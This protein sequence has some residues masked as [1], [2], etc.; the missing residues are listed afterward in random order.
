MAHLCDDSKPIQSAS[1]TSKKRCRD[2]GSFDLLHRTI[3]FAASDNP[4]RCAWQN[5]A[6]CRAGDRVSVI[7]DEDSSSSTPQWNG[8]E[9]QQP[10]PSPLVIPARTRP[11]KACFKVTGTLPE[12]DP[13]RRRDPGAGPA[14]IADARNFLPLLRFAQRSLAGPRRNRADA[15]LDAFQPRR[16]P[17]S[18]L[19]PRRSVGTSMWPFNRSESVSV[20]ISRYC[21]QLELALSR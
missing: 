21:R 9:A 1:F 10:R 19:V 8:D 5:T 16:S 7:D 3:P 15:V 17:G 18:V 12:S 4:D 20:S 14:I 11:R 6:G 13:N 2:E